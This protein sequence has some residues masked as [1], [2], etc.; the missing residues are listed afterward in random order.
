MIGR[1]RAAEK[2]AE[3]DVGLPRKTWTREEAHVLVDIGFPNAEKLELIN[4]ELIDRMGKKR[5][6]VMWK[7][8]IHTWLNSVFG[9]EH[10]Q[11][12]DPIDVADVDANLSEPEPDLAVTKKSTRE[13]TKHPDPT[14]LLLVMEIS[15]ST[16]ILDLTV[17]AKL[18]ARAAI[19]DYWV[20]DI[21][22]KLVYVHRSPGQG[23][24]TS[25]VKYEF[26][27]E[28]TPLANMDAIFCAAKL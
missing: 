9:S 2:F 13:Y 6:H 18:Y 25:M 11:V 14:D 4:G 27:E 23:I 20:V 3:L 15:D 5:P 19:S 8:L 7:N 26:D 10:V 12:E 24:Y 16:L 22:N 21:Q 1:M 17:K 28:I